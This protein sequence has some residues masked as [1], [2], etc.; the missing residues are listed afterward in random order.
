VE[1]EDHLR[2]RVAWLAAILLVLAGMAY[3]ALSAYVLASSLARQPLP[4]PQR[5]PVDDS[6]KAEAV[7]FTSVPDGVALSGWLM[8][9]AGTRAIV[10]VHRIDSYGWEGAAQDL[11]IQYFRAGF[12]VLVFD[13][14]AHGRSG[15]DRRGLGWDERADVMG[16]VEFLLS[17]GIPAGRI[18]LHGTSYGAAAALLAAAEIPQVGAIVADSA[19]ADVRDLVSVQVA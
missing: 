13:L 14:R 6:L 11:A 9:S 3:I 17:R 4:A 19:F 18:G 8:R 15:G 7:S 10:L 1:D 12:D 5:S 2:S 16:A